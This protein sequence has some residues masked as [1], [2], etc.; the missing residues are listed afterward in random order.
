[1]A[2]DLRANFPE[3]PSE[4]QTAQGGNNWNDNCVPTSHAYC[5][6]ALGYTFVPPQNWTDFEYGSGYHGGEYMASSI[7]YIYKHPDLF[8]NPPLITLEAPGD[9]LAFIQENGAKGFPMCAAF[10]CNVNA[11]IEPN[12]GF[13]HISCP[14]AAD[15]NGVTIWNVWSGYEQYLSNDLF[16]ECYSGGVTVFH[17]SI[18]PPPIKKIEDDEEDLMFL[19][20]EVAPGE[21]KAVPGCYVGPVGDKSYT[22]DWNLYVDDHDGGAAGECHVFAQSLDAKELKHDKYSIPVD[23][24]VYGDC[25]GKDSLGGDWSLSGS[26]TLRFWNTGA[27]KVTV[28]VHRE[29]A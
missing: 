2:F 5:M 7:D 1:M 21:V 24:E 28:A 8:P 27:S 14:V 17:Q 25:G 23:S 16:R 19:R 10:S 26:F 12:G 15:D 13:F 18:F 22:T 29:R 3:I 11:H 6:Q 4:S 9:V 20:L